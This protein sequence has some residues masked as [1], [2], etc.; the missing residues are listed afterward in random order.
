MVEMSGRG[1]GFLS[2]AGRWAG[3]SS[4]GDE[5]VAEAGQ[6]RGES[7]RVAVRVEEAE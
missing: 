7:G 4:G 5:F 1:R 2:D 6:L 3:W